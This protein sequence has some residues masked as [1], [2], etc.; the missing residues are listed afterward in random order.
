VQGSRSS[1][2]GLRFW[3]YSYGLRNQG[4]DSQFMDKRHG[5]R[6]IGCGF[7]V[8]GLGFGLRRLSTT[9]RNDYRV[10]GFWV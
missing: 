5:L 10:L 2:Q 8:H 4:G 6:L 7:I 1:I 9:P 3:V